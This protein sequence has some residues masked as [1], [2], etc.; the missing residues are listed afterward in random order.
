MNKIDLTI[1]V[2]AEISETDISKPNTLCTPRH[3]LREARK[4]VCVIWVN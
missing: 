1:E 3:H 2:T 4:C